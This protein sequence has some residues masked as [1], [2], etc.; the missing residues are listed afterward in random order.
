MH[1]MFGSR[2]FAG[3]TLKHRSIEASKHWRQALRSRTLGSRCQR[4]RWRCGSA[5]MRGIVARRGTT[6]STGAGGGD[7]DW[8]G[9]AGFE[10]RTEVRVGFSFRCSGFSCQLFVFDFNMDM[11]SLWR[12]DMDPCEVWCSVRWRVCSSLLVKFVQS[13]TK[14]AV[15]LSPT[16]NTCWLHVS[17]PWQPPSPLDPV[18]PL[19]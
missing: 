13:K 7:H 19:V 6:G 11:Q 4:R 1:Q 18:M 10:V 5:A 16:K 9:G 3:F 17:Y 2:V 15:V 12:L 8:L 14:N